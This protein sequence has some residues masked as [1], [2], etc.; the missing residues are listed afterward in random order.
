MSFQIGDRVEFCGALLSCDSPG[1]GTVVDTL[2]VGL[3]VIEWDSWIGVP[4]PIKLEEV[5]PYN[6][7]ERTDT[8]E[9]LAQY[10]A[11]LLQPSDVH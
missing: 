7:G 4:C 3:V 11:F 6:G 8:P 2:R 5:K 9:K 1:Y 10:R